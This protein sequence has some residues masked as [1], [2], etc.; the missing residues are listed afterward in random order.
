MSATQRAN[1]PSPSSIQPA[2]LELTKLEGLGND[3]LVLL[4]EPT[5]GMSHLGEGEDLAELARRICL[6]HHGLGADGLILGVKCSGPLAALEFKLWNA[7]GSVAQM[8]GNGMRCLA[9]AALD[10]GWVQ[11]DAPFVVATPAGPRS[12]SV[13]RLSPTTAWAS[14]GMGQ[15]SI[16]QSSHA[17]NVGHGQ[18]RVEVG[19]PHLVV[20]GADPAGIDVPSLG[21]ALSASEPGGLN[22]E[23]VALGPEP[24]M[25][26]M[27]VFERGVGETLACGTGSVAAAAAFHHWGRV[28]TSVTVR[29]PG[30]EAAVELHEDG[31]AS[32][33]GPTRLVARCEV[34]A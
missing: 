17:C 16:S 30:G 2:W 29:Q 10:A 31:T 18:L 9:H 32:L 1:V 12:V 13:R 27:R 19:N 7:D 24:D 33:A 15:V 34:P 14:V 3:F 11:E 23:F 22:V 8:S 25:L 20:A 4:A 28:G 21:A 26:T 5:K 6:R